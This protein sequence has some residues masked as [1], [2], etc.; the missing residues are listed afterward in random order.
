ME[1]NG[2]VLADSLKKVDLN[3]LLIVFLDALFY[4]L[5]GLLIYYWFSRVKD[6]LVSFNI[7]ADFI[8]LGYQRQDIVNEVRIFY[9]VLIVSFILLLAAIIF[10]ASVLKG[11]IWAKTT[12]T[13]ITFALISRFL[14]LNL[15]WMG[16]W[17]IFILVLSIL[18]KP[19]VSAVVI[20]PSIIISLY[21]SNTLYTLFMKDQ[22]LRVIWKSVRISTAKAHMFFLPYAA[23]GM[24]LFILIKV[25]AMLNFRYSQAIIA[26]ALIILAAFARYFHSGLVFALEKE[27]P[28]SL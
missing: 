6:K 24:I 1:W 17:F 4:A 18:F 16:F 21:L 13:R 11:I 9:I 19:S 25:N 22:K 3:I 12:K 14:V 23:L 2:R 10:L 26:S 8:S 15:S 7:P 27:K 20:F 5:S 28:K